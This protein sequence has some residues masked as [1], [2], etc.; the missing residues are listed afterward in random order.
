M[1]SVSKKKV[2]DLKTSPL[3]DKIVSSWEIQPGIIINSNDMA[4]REFSFVGS[5][6]SPRG[7]KSS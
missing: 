6:G 5:T 2:G 4:T 3:N 1:V 7:E